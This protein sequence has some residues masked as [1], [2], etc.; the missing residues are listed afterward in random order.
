[1]LFTVV[2]IYI[3]WTIPLYCVHYLLLF[4]L[5]YFELITK[6]V[7]NPVR[8]SRAFLHTQRDRDRQ[9]YKEASS[10]LLLRER[11]VCLQVTTNKLSGW[12]PV[13]FTSTKA[14]IFSLIPSTQLCTWNHVTQGFS[15]IHFYR[16]GV[17]KRTATQYAPKI[18]VRLRSPQRQ[19]CDRCVVL[20]S[21]ERP[22]FTQHLQRD[23]GHMTMRAGMTSDSLVLILRWD[24]FFGVNRSQVHALNQLHKTPVLIY[25][26]TATCFG[27]KCVPSS[28]PIPHAKIINRSFVVFD[29]F[30]VKLQSRFSIFFIYSSLRVPLS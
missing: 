20:W 16:V 26:F 4:K 18:R 28:G 8:D 21:K 19:F 5:V 25:L 14:R 10:W 22:H 15:L 12:C 6:S 2:K 29:S 7:K 1:M 24:I 27:S 3:L 30:V 17:N 13:F 11:Q 9:T 23:S